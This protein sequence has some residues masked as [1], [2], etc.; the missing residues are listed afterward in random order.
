MTVPQQEPLSKLESSRIPATKHSNHGFFKR[1]GGVSQGHYA[2]LNCGFG[3]ND[4]SENVKTNRALAATALGVSS[5]NLLT[6]FQVHSSKVA[7]VNDAWHAATAPHADALVTR[8]PGLALGILTADCAPVLFFDG[9]NKI[10]GAAHAGWKGTLAGILEETV[11]AMEAIGGHRTSIAAAVGPCI[12][13]KN[14]QVG[15]EF[16]LCF[17]DFDRSTEQYFLPSLDSQL[18]DYWQFDLKGFVAA[19]L[20]KLN[21]SLVEILDTCSYECEKEFFSYRRATQ[22]NERDYGRNLSAI[23]LNAI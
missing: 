18:I 9:K 14:Y 17:I 20:E 22:R 21:L 12:S 19:R 2:S 11:A 4:T 3:S 8:L 1:T 16:K 5:E 6:V 10:V 23:V 7:T 15:P 13:Q